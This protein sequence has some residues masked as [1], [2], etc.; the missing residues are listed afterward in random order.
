M[1]V[2]HVAS[3]ALIMRI[4][5]ALDDDARAHPN[6]G[7]RLLGSDGSGEK[8]QHDGTPVDVLYLFRAYAMTTR[9]VKKNAK[10]DAKGPWM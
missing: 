3:S 1:V 7:D 9:C 4:S 10:K 2:L 6:H 8:G 5:F